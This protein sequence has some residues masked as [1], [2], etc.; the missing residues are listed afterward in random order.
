[1]TDDGV[2]SPNCPLC[3]APPTFRMDRQCFCGSEDCPVFTWDAMGD[4][5]EF[6]ATAKLISLS[7]DEGN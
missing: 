2:R 6:F 7:P 3:K 1:M 5:D 4:P